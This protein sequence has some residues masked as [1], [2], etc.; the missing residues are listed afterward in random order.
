MTA[1]EFCLA[2]VGGGPRSTYALERL[3]ATI[4]RLGGRRLAVHVYDDGGDFGAGQVHSA[5]QP[6][7]SYLN[8]AAHQVGF[9][10]DPS[11]TDAEPIRDDRP[12]LY[13][14]CRER[15]ATTGD[16]TFD[17]EPA[18][19]PKRH[20]HGQALREMFDA[21]AG[22][23]RGKGVSVVLHAEEVT[24]L[25]PADGRWEVVSASGSHHTADQVLLITGHS[26]NDYSDE[27]GP[28]EYLAFARRTGAV[29]MPSAYP[30]QEALSLEDPRPGSTV[31][32][33]GLGL[34]A[35][36]QILYLT[37]G[38]GG[39]F[40]LDD[41]RL[42]YQASG[43]EP[44]MILAF[45]PSGVFPYTRPINRKDRPH[46]GRFLTKTAIDKI[47]KS[48]GTDAGDDRPRLDFDAHVMPLILLE[49]AYLHYRTLFGPVAGDLIVESVHEDY[50][51]FLTLPIEPG[52]VERLLPGVEAV[53]ATLPKQLVPEPMLKRFDWRTIL[54]PIDT[55]A[56]MTRSEFRLTYLDFLRRDLDWAVQGN[57][58]NS[59]KASVDGVWRDLRGVLSHAVDG[60]GLTADSHRRFL[61]YHRRCQNKVSGGA[62]PEVMAKILALAEHGVLDLSAGPRAKIAFSDRSFVLHGPVTGLNAELD[63][64]LDA[65]VHAFDPARD[66]RPLYRNLIGRDVV[67]LWR[68]TTPGQADFVPGFLDLDERSRPVGH[69]SITVLGPAAAARGTY[70]FSALRPDNNDVVMREIVA[71]L[72]G[73]WAALDHRRLP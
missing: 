72:H 47:R 24:D 33:A 26:S 68:N 64:L 52:E 71:W 42:R 30:L 28:G 20:Q 61:E 60:G 11:V 3:S 51:R 6:F 35:I 56:G 73:F 59:F 14:W 2:I 10:A 5:S 62:A 49:M 65:R 31:G 29:Y 67:R 13:D 18:D 53:V 48:S 46:Q 63:V 54:A 25:V 32:C 50:E 22:E 38:R 41:D 45:S 19:A 15:F 39:Q 4:D 16:T 34:T 37:E 7:T 43:S 55:S 8:R 17:L 57:V 36:D 70:Q 12:T 23:L 66:I 1:G 69:G 27:D 58:A 21:Y 40:L 44:A 9:A